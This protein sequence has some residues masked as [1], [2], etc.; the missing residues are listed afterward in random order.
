MTP[1]DRRL[2][3]RFPLRVPVYIRT[4]RSLETEREVESINLSES[5]VY[6]ETDAPPPD[7]TIIHLRLEVP[8]EITGRV[9]TE[10]RCIGKVVRV[11]HLAD[12][13]RS[14]VA[15]HFAYHE[16]VAAAQFPAARTA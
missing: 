9:G 7:A 10:W 5:G 3:L 12:C 2:A 14:G 16:A 6:F 11:T 4:W 15:V 13:S 1:S 8:H